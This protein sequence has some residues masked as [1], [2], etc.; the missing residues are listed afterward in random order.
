MIFSA[1][2]FSV[3][4]S[5]L[6]FLLEWTFVLRGGQYYIVL[7]NEICTGVKAAKGGITWLKVR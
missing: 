3:T 7:R 1:I 6:V 5:A 2:C 4:V